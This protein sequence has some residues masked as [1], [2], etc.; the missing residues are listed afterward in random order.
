V[1]GWLA[2]KS[3]LVRLAA[4]PDST[5]WGQRIARG[6][7]RVAAVTLLEIGFSARSGADVRAARRRPPLASMPI[8]RL[9]PAMEDRALEVQALLADHGQHRAP[10][11]PDLLIAA[12]AE[13]RGLVVLHVDKDY[14]LIAQITDQPLERL[15]T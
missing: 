4:S 10:A 9:T 7:V 8:E 2:D 15:R 14:E 3:A 13:L 6:V 11:V 5:A 12:V 1:T